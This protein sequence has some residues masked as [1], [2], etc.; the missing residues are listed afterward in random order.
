MAFRE[1]LRR[2]G[3][4]RGRAGARV[5]GRSCRRAQSECQFIETLT[6]GYRPPAA[7]RRFRKP[8]TWATAALRN[9]LLGRFR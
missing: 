8:A 9:L 5:P 3:K 1:T 6:W 7:A 2:C 4:T